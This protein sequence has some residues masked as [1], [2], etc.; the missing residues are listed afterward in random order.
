LPC[1]FSLAVRARDHRGLGGDRQAAG[2]RRRTRLPAGAQRRMAAAGLSCLARNGPKPRGRKSRRRHCG[3]AIEA[4][5]SC[6]QRSSHQEAAWVARLTASVG[7]DVAN[8]ACTRGPA[9]WAK[10]WKR[11]RTER[12][13]QLFGAEDGTRVAVRSLS[14]MDIAAM[15]LKR[16]KGHV[17]HGQAGRSELQ[18]AGH[19]TPDK[20]RCASAILAAVAAENGDLKS[21]ALPCPVSRG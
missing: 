10:E 6:G 21:I 3:K 17:G 14:A 9:Q 7:E 2:D 15:Q 19:L 4:L 16:C 13:P 12:R 1:H 8:M 18:Y 5:P 20:T 11:W